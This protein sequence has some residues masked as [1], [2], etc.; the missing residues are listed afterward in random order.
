[1]LELV[2][3]RSAYP[4]GDQAGVPAEYSAPVPVPVMVPDI[5]SSTIFL[6]VETISEVT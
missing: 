5:S 3:G 6:I 2:N 1:M 4:A